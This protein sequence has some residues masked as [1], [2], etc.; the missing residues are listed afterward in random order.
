M[1]LDE[2]LRL[3]NLS[4]DYKEYNVKSSSHPHLSHL[5]RGLRGRNKGLEYLISIRT[6][7]RI[8]VK[9]L[10]FFLG[11]VFVCFLLSVISYM[12]TKSKELI[13][14]LMEVGKGYKKHTCK[15]N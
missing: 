6:K 9:F 1:V 4:S 10:L 11:F 7:A 13:T 14:G 12:I 8:R 15:H 5:L 3:S 2:V